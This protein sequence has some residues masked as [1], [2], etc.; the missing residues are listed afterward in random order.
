[1]TLAKD[2]YT[3]SWNKSHQWQLELLHHSIWV[4]VTGGEASCVVMLYSLGL[5]FKPVYG[6]LYSA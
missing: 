1:M 6:S 4:L 5:V 3:C 2:E